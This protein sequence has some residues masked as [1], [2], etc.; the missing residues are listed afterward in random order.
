MRMQNYDQQ[1]DLL[2]LGIKVESFPLGIKEAFES[3]MRTFGANRSY[4]GISWCFDASTIE[5]YATVQEA[6]TGEAKKFNYKK[7]TIP[8]GL[9]HTATI[10]DWLGKT[11]CIKDVF[12]E[13][14]AGSRPTESRPCIEWYKSDHEMLCMIKSDWF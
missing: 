4:Y 1:E 10:V 8:K 3:L 6:F 13:L 14:T 9:Y 7:L 12:N 5:Y 11:D 2:L